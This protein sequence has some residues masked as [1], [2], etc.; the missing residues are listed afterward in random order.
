MQDDHVNML[1]VIL[2]SML[3]CIDHKSMFVNNNLSHSLHVIVHMTANGEY[4][5]YIGN[6]NEAASS[7][8]P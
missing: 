8:S 4:T 7:V 2:Q 3:Q 5:N 6:G 1:C